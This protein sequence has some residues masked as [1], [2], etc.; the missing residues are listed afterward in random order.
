MPSGKCAAEAQDRSM[1]Q[2][3]VHACK[4]SSMLIMFTTDISQDA[5][6]LEVQQSMHPLTKH[7]STMHSSTMHPLT[8]H[9]STMMPSSPQL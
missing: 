8:M 4:A 1:V 2:L 5:N 7:P 9:P 6:I 3:I